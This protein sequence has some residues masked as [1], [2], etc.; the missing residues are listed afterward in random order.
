MCYTE[1]HRVDGRASMLHLIESHM[2]HNDIFRYYS[3]PSLSVPLKL[4]GCDELQEGAVTL[5]VLVKGP[6]HHRNVP[7]SH[8]RGYETCA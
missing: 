6:L 5:K 8:A 2:E 3:M 4:S 7:Q 1:L